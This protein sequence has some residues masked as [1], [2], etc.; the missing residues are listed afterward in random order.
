[1]C[2]NITAKPGRHLFSVGRLYRLATYVPYR[3]PP[4]SPF[5]GTKNNPSEMRRPAYCPTLIEYGFWLQ[6]RVYCCLGHYVNGSVEVTWYKSSGEHFR[7]CAMHCQPHRPDSTADGWMSCCGFA[8]NQL[9]QRIRSHE[10]YIDIIYDI[11]LITC[12]RSYLLVQRRRCSGL[13][14]FGSVLGNKVSEVYRHNKM[15]R[16][17]CYWNGVAGLAFGDVFIVVYH[18]GGIS[19]WYHF[20]GIRWV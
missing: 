8:L 19:Q 15:P 6:F 20:D 12:R 11:H 10:L 16:Y 5:R 14:S 2:G 9:D 4:D 7:H 1:M 17:I 18:C 13:G 3:L